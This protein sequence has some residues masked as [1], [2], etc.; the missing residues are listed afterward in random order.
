MSRRSFVRSL[1]YL[2]SAV[3]VCLV[4][5]LLITIPGAWFPGVSERG[6]GVSELTVSRGSGGVSERELV[7]GADAT[8]LALVSVVTSFRASEYPAV[9]WLAADIPEGASVRLLWRTDYAPEKLN[10]VAIAV[11]AGRTLPAVLAR[12]PAWL[13]R[14]TGLALAIQAK[15]PQPARISG[16]VA[17]PMGAVELLRDRTREWFSFEGWTGASINTITGGADVQ[18]LPLPLL[19]ACAVVLATVIAA[20][21]QHWRPGA[22]GMGVPV[23][24]GAMF[25]VAWFVLDARWTANLARQEAVTA[26]QYA[27]KDTAARHLAAEDGALFAFVERARARLPQQ[28]ARVFIAADADYFRG[29]AAYHLYPHS[30]YSEPR[31]NTLP[32]ARVMKPGDWLLV[33]QRRGIQYDP[34]RQLLRWEG[35]Q[36]RSAEL[37]YVEPGGALFL[38]R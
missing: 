35:D 6:F 14:V 36:T 15:A 3:V 28:P 31:A 25:L 30:V 32:P 22:L 17:K 20:L 19:L 2:A 12:N 21:V 29:R 5:Y 24:A 23:L 33:F 1:L 13:G 10:S 27:G 7:V 37:K 4:T 34:A 11:E 18:D 26:H 9:H 16:V 8:G 38:I